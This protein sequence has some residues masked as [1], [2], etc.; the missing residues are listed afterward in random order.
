[1][2]SLKTRPQHAEAP[3]VVENAI[4]QNF[5]FLPHYYL[6]FPI[7]LF[8]NNYKTTLERF[9]NLINIKLKNF[10]RYSLKLELLLILH[11]NIC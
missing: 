4:I 6:D 5:M 9:Q 7:I 8:V 10:G 2:K 1:M 3:L 11:N